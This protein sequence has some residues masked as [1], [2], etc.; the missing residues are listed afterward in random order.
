MKLQFAE[1]FARLEGI[2]E[3]FNLPGTRMIV[4]L[5][6]KEEFKTAGGLIVGD[7]GGYRTEV[8]TNRPLI[9][10]VLLVGEG[11]TNEEG[12]L[13][14]VPFSPGAV[15]Q[16][17]THGPAYYS[18]YPGIG[19]TSDIA[20]IVPSHVNMSWPSIADYMKFREVLSGT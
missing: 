11:S 8:Q 15:V 19:K 4:E 5:L 2:K 3:S 20:M 17:N 16:I 18:E 9:G 14:E 10:V 12:E 13:E 6:P 1:K 7:P